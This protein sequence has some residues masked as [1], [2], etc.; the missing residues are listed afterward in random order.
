MKTTHEEA[1]V[2]AD[3]SQFDTRSGSLLERLLFNHRP[4]LMLACL[5]LTGFFVAQLPQLTLNA[6]FQRMIPQDHPFV[7]NF[8]AHQDSLAGQ[9]NV[10]RVVVENTRGSILDKDYLQ[11]LQKISDEV[12]LLAGVN[13]PYMKSLWTPTMRWHGITESGLDEGQVIDSHYDGSAESLEQLRLN[14]ERSGEIGSIVAGNFNSS[15]LLVPLLDIDTETGEQLNYG[16]FGARLEDIRAKYQSEHIRL[17]IVGFAKVVGDLIEGLTQVL[18]FFAVAI[19]IAGLVVFAY[20][21]CLRSTVLVL[22]CSLIAVIWLLGSLPLLGYEL[23]PYTVLVPFLVF[24]IGM[25]HGAQ[26]MNGILQD[27][28]RGTHRLIAARYTFRRLF[29]AGLMALACD[30]VGFAV[31]LLIKI[32]VIRQLSLTASLGVAFLIFTNLILLPILLSYIGVGRHAAARSL[33]SEQAQLEEKV[34]PALWRWLDLFTR[35]K[36]AAPTLLVAMALGVGGFMVS[37]HLKIGDLDPGAPE[38]RTDSR[39]NQDNAYITSNY[40]SSSDVFIVM[41]TSAPQ[42]CMNYALL[43]RIDRLEWRLRQQPGVVATDSFAAFIKV[44]T[45]QLTEGN[46][47][48]ISLLPNQAV[49]N[50]LVK[51]VP[52]SLVNQNCDLSMLRI[53]LR[54]HKAETLQALVAEIQAFAAANDQGDERFQMAAGSAGIEAATNSV[55]QKANREMLLWVYGAVIV[56]C[57][58]VFRSW[59][60]VACAI[61]PLMLTSVLAEALMVWLDIGVKVATLPVIALGV[62]IGIDY[63]LYVLSILL[64]HLRSGESLSLAYY[65]SLLFTGRVVLLTGATL[66]IGVATWVFSPIKFQADMGILLAFMF[67]WNMLGALVLLP[68]LAS[69]LLKPAPGQQVLPQPMTALRKAACQTSSSHRT[70]VPG[71]AR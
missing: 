46:P 16:A 33:R 13:R 31:L 30:A 60:A 37:L 34:R 59:R 15:M 38:L 2:I 48:W 65:R 32:E 56:L 66:A 50:N 55:V 41:V 64:L 26:K 14:I 28:G 52:Q 57:F 12:Y 61:L 49:I 70:L 35:R 29:M 24:A 67:L 69:F 25:S 23:D 17:H 4:W 62:G 22:F 3:L 7:I 63:A 20:T 11:T 9:G 1:P 27:I 68:A 45:S 71:S 36:V 5:L 44:M 58:L 51:Y 39:Y 21:R 18:V 43:E 19:L 6:S 42:Q 40:G 10:V 54:D 8:Q 47:K 53:F